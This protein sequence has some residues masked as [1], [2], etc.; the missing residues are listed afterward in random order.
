[1]NENFRPAL[2]SAS[3]N[4]LC[5]CKHYSPYLELVETN[6]TDILKSPFSFGHIL[7]VL[8]SGAKTKGLC[9]ETRSPGVHFRSRWRAA[10]MNALRLASAPSLPL[11]TP[12]LPPVHLSDLSDHEHGPFHSP[13]RVCLIRAFMVTSC[14][15]SR[16]QAPLCPH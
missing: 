9:R 6:P 2:R 12:T 13:A 4:S 16:C 8:L 11:S 1:M 7:R 10:L 15:L 3:S 14:D 5:M